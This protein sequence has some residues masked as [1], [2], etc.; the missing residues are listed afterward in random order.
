MHAEIFKSFALEA[1]HR[2]PNV[3][4][5]H[6]CAR[7][8]GHSFQVKVTVGGTVGD[9]SGWVYDFADLAEAWQPIHD[10]LDHRYLNDVEGL[11]NPTSERLARWIWQRLRDTLPGLSEVEVKETCTTGCRYRGD[12]HG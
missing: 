5:D 8:H 1:A 7:V 4:P 11:D 9:E 3:A 12:D 6:K 2:L 10:A